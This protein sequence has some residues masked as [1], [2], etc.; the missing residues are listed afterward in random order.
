MLLLFRYPDP[1]E[2]EPYARTRRISG[3]LTASDGVQQSTSSTGGS[4]IVSLST[5]V[6]T[7]TTTTSSSETA[8]QAPPNEENRTLSELPVARKSRPVLVSE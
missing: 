1:F 8:N 6:T 4:S 3:G 7:T 2:S 5:T